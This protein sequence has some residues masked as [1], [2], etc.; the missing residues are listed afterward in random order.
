MA[1][2]GSQHGASGIQEQ[3][4]R[5]R[6][7]TSYLRGELGQIGDALRVLG[8]KQAA[9]AKAEVREQLSQSGKVAALGA[10]ALVFGSIAMVFV[11][12]TIMFVLWVALPMWAAGLVTTVLLVAASAL[13]GLMAYRHF[14]GVSPM[15]KRTAASLR[16][17]VTWVKQ[18]LNLNGR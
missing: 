7:E 4:E 9:L 2:N 5:A 15:P 11:S 6:E 12:L 10:A 13:T 18:Q 8:E 3:L 16:E 1:M 17:D 14:K